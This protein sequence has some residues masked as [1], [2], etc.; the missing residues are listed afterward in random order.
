[1]CALATAR[2]RCT[3]TAATRFVKAQATTLHFP[4]AEN[5][6][7][8][9][10]FPLPTKALAFA[11]TPLTTA[12]AVVAVVI[13]A[14]HGAAVAAAAEQDQQ[15]DDPA[16]VPTTTVITHK[17]IPPRFLSDFPAAHSNIFHP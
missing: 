17:T 8:S 9:L 6:T 3:P 1:M 4:Q 14:A 13:A 2:L 5:A 11:G 7:C 12:A 15:N 10:A 16:P